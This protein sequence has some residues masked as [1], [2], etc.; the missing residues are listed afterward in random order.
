MN[1]GKIIERGLTAFIPIYDNGNITKVFTVDGMEILVRKTCRT[2]LRNF[3]RFYGVDLVA[4]REQYGALINKRLGIPIPMSAKILLI[5]VKVRN[6]PLG[7]NDGTLGYI[8]FR[9]IKQIEDAKNGRCLVMFQYN[10][11]LTIMVSSATMK[12]YLKNAKLVENHYLKQHFCG[13]R[14]ELNRT[15]K[16]LQEPSVSY[17]HGIS[18]SGNDEK[19]STLESIENEG[20]SRDYLIK[21][22]IDTIL[23]LKNQVME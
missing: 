8:N 3:A 6:N 22:L 13:S 14:E 19:G 20:L 5:P 23:M 4:I 11:N 9:E 16:N 1:V 17:I 2:V 18:P 7:K 21:L 12:E 15:Y 10:K